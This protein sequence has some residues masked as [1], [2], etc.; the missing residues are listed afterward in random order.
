MSFCRGVRFAHGLRKLGIV[1]GFRYLPRFNTVCRSTL[2]MQNDSSYSITKFGKDFVAGLIVFLVA[3]PLCLGIAI[4]SGADPMAGLIAG[5]VGALIT[6]VL[7][8]SHTSVSGPAA[9][10]TAIVAGQ[11]TQLG[12]FETFLLAVFLAGVFQIVLGV[13]KAGV[14]SAFFPT[15]V[16]K[17]LLAAIGVILILGQLPLLVGLQKDL[18]GKSTPVAAVDATTAGAPTADGNKGANDGVS[19][20]VEGLEGHDSAGH[21]SAGHGSAGHGHEIGQQIF[22]FIREMTAVFEY[23]NGIQWGAMLIGLISL[24]FLI[25]WDQIKALKKSLVPS[26]LVVVILGSVL[27][28]LFQRLGWGQ[29]WSLADNHYVFVPTA[30]SWEDIRGF[31]RFPDFSQLAN[32]GVYVA[33]VT[34]AIV[35]SLET[36]LNLEAVDKL[37]KKQRV[38]PPNRELVAQGFGNLCC[39]LIGGLP[40]TSVVIRGSVNVNAGNETKVSAII[41]GVLLG[42]CVVT[43]PWL[44]NA[45]PLSCLAAILLMTGY[46]LASPTLFQAM[47]KE[48]RYQLLPFVLTLVSIVLTDLLVGVIIG[49]VLSLLFILY[50][51]VR[52]PIRMIHEN[53]IDG[54]LLHVEL[55]NQVSFLNKASLSAAMREAKPGSRLL[56]DARR[57]DYIDPDV[58]GIIREFQNKT[59]LA[60]G[61]RLQLVGFKDSYRFKSKEDSVDYSIVEAR[62]SLTPAQVQSVLNEG[63]RRF[64]EG[65]PIDRDLRPGNGSSDAHRPIA[66]FYT[67]IDS[68][69]PVEMLFDLGIGD[70]FGLRTPGAVFSRHAL[71]GLEY[72]AT[73]GGIKLIV[74]MSRYD[75]KLVE[76]VVRRVSEPS[77]QASIGGC[78][79]LESVLAEIAESVD[80]TAAARFGS[81]P[82]H[83]QRAMVNRF[84]E[85]Q[86]RRTIR[87]ILEQSRVI[88]ELVES[89]KLK[90]VP[91]LLDTT[92][93]K[94]DFLD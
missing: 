43:I 46:K 36:L 12:A 27:G 55:A 29:G 26:A 76:M 87:L 61:I 93:G 14:L 77:Y 78:E 68:K 79:N 32:S 10:L 72:A 81:L 30:Q 84:S 37:D 80:R 4:G 94:A 83:E 34:L 74:V 54:E 9:G 40:V 45:I 1:P 24:I 8:G 56:I 6:G 44:L 59:A 64:V 5:V 49:L 85:L 23:D 70:A 7:S 86:I 66:A 51:N 91:V 82:E 65:H 18:R 20:A 50:S 2:N 13:M 38:S 73:V 62:E 58:L 41:H 75:S 88:R 71:G 22:K 17:G 52:R 3:L 15:S 19:N 53:H 16:I 33:A 57:T 90:I 69:T 25:V 48:G 89:G 28:M 63:N 11:I 67:G 92:N 42:G 47:A 21:D 39:G 60:L 31:A 35:A